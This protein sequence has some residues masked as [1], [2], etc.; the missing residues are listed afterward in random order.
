MGKKCSSASK[1]AAGAAVGAAVAAGAA[2]FFTQTKTGKKMV[3][4]AHKHALHLGREVA[5]KA[6]KAKTLTEKK[7]HKI[8]DEVVEEY[9]SKKKLTKDVSTKVKRDLKTNWKNVKKGL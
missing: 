9:A 4:D 1:F 7:Y 5:K 8:V 6:E 3:K 2:L